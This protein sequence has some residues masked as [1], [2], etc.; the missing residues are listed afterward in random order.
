VLEKGKK[1][2][3]KIPLEWQGVAPA[4][5]AGHIVVKTMHE[6]EIEV[7]PAE[8]P[9]FLVVD[10]TK[11]VDIGSHITAA[12]LVLPPSA[13][14]VTKGDE[15]VASVTEFKE[16]KVEVTPPPETVILTAKTEEGAEGAAAPAEEKPAQGGSASGG[17]QKSA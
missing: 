4:E 7:A 5:K 11:L 14:L 6:V 10:L 17:K 3:I 9:R 13:V 16:E 15:T 2:T 12:D 1:I 8:L